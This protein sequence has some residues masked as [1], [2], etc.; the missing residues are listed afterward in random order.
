MSTLEGVYYIP[1]FKIGKQWRFSEEDLKEWL[2]T[3]KVYKGKNAD[4]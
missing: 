1:A 2:K 4:S 3:K